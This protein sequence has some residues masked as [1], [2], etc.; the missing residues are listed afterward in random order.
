LSYL[1]VGLGCELVVDQGSERGSS[2]GCET[3]DDRETVN[4][5]FRVV[6]GLAGCRRGM[7]HTAMGERTGR[8]VME[9]RREHDEMQEG[10]VL[11]VRPAGTGLG[12]SL[13]AMERVKGLAKQPVKQLWTGSVRDYG[14][15]LPMDFVPFQAKHRSA[16]LASEHARFPYLLC[17]GI[18]PSNENAI[19]RGPGTVDGKAQAKACRQA[20][21]VASGH[22]IVPARAT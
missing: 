13:G 14:V 4:G 22:A 2:R 11:V 19:F 15:S 5:G 18:E 17:E 1:D 9:E 21:A 6:R 8:G 16:A 20:T 3:D 7:V 12:A 10:M